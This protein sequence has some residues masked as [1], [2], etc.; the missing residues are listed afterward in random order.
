MQV[1]AAD[2]DLA[3]LLRAGD[4]IIVGQAGAEPLTLTRALMRAAPP[5]GCTVFV[6]MVGSDSFAAPPTSPNGGLGFESYGAI[7]KAAGLARLGRLSVLP[8]HYS[9]LNR[10]FAEGTLRADC[11]LVQLAPGPGGRGYNL[12]FTRDY[13]LEAAR[14]ARLVIAEINPDA[15]CCHGGEW[16]GDIPIHIL[17][18][19]DSAPLDLPAP[20][21]GAVDLAIGGHVA[22]LIPDRAVL[23]L[24]VGAL[25]QAVTARLTGHRGLGLHSGVMFDGVLDL[26]EAGALTNAGKET[27]TGTSVAG[28]LVGTRRLRDFAHDN[29]SF[30]LAP[31]AHTHAHGVM[32]GLSRFCAVNS[33]VE[34]DLTG[35]VNA[36]TAG[37]RYVGG[38]GGQV[39]FMRGA[40]AS[41]GG[42]AIIALPATAAGGRVSRIVPQ[43]AIVTCARADVD[44]IVTE[45]G[46]AELRGCSLDE[47]ARRMVAI[48][49]PEFRE[50]LS[51]HWHDHGRAAHE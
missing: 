1:T 50:D 20:A 2:L 34:V 11:I 45:W 7:G 14:H 37:G 42:R 23:Q 22:G 16:P 24:G 10:A 12:G 25:P 17:V 15:P 44:A 51:R 41:A 39:D 27:D 18:P 29:P 48:A 28:L 30:R 36:E 38:V 35:Q 5:P 3:A 8:M 6:G 46:V 4:R 21:P 26:I 9:A 31:P 49:A 32:A 47:R 40:N 19:A 13:L 33:A 43:A